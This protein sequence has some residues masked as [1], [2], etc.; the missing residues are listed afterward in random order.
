LVFKSSAPEKVQMPRS[1]NVTGVAVVGVLAWFGAA[2]FAAEVGTPTA[3]SPE[4]TASRVLPTLTLAQPTPADPAEVLRATVV[5]RLLASLPSPDG[6]LRAEIVT[7]ACT[8]VEGEQAYAL[9]QLVIR[10][11]N[12]DSSWV[13]DEQLQACGGLGAYGL[14]GLYRSSDSQRF[15]S[16]PAREGV[17][18]G[19][20][21]WFPPIAFADVQRR[22]VR[23][24]GAGVL[25]R[26]AASWLSIRRPGSCCGT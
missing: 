12:P 4:P 15:Y 9:D 13:A 17:P 5:P 23:E 14:G 19:C 16:T 6:K 10:G 8:P 3:E 2:G 21:M 26:T 24:L 11:S 18:D 22:F 1:R 20:G 25:S 7:Y